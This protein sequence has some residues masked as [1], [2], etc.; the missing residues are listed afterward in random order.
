MLRT[1]SL[2][3]APPDAVIAEKITAA[4][5]GDG[6]LI[7]QHSLADACADW[8]ADCSQF[9]PRAACIEHT[10]RRDNFWVIRNIDAGVGFPPEKKRVQG[11]I[12]DADS[13]CRLLEDA[14]MPF[15]PGAGNDGGQ[16]PVDGPVDVTRLLDPKVA[17]GVGAL[18]LV[19]AVAWA[20][21]RR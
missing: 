7:V 1:A 17:F 15:N 10:V 11:N 6:L 19:G 16:G 21:F 20:K 5:R 4:V 9:M 2:G 8:G 13:H 3:Q 12:W 14:G 18:A